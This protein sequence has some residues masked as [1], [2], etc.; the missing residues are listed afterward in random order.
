MSSLRFHGYPNLRFRDGGRV[1]YSG[2]RRDDIGAGVDPY[3]ETQPHGPFCDCQDCLDR[4]SRDESFGELEHQ[5]AAKKGVRNP[6]ALAAWIGRE[7]G[8]IPGKNK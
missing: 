1:V 8:K 3:N 4:R 7:H 6:K 2:R 5:L